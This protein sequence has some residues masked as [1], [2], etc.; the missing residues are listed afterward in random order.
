MK[1]YLFVTILVLALSAS[2]IE[3]QEKYLQCPV[4]HVTVFRQGAQLYGEIPVSIGAETVDFVAGG[5]SPYIDPNS[6]QVR[7]EGGFMI[8]GVSHRNNYLENPDEAESIR[9]LRDRIRELEL[10]IEDEKTAVEILMEKELFLKSNYDVVTN[11]SAITPEQLR[12]LLDIYSSNTEDVKMAVLK[13]RRV[14]KE[15]EEEKQKLEKQLSA[16]V[17]MSKMP[18][19]EILVTVTGTKPAT[20]RLK[21]SYVV[22]NAGWRPSYDIRVDDIADPA[23]IIY[24]AGI[25]Q[26]SGIDWKDVKVS[27]SN[28]S[29]MTAGALPKLNPWFIDFY[30]PIAYSQLNEVVMIRGAKSMPSAREKKADDAIMME[31]ESAPLP[32]TVTESNISFSFDVNVPQTI[33]SGGKTETVELQRLTAPATYSYAVTPKLSTSAY[34]MGYITDWEKYNLLA[35]ESN[36]YF[37]NTFTGKGY[38]N[39]AELT[40]TLPVSLGADNS[41]TVKRER[42]TDYTSQRLIGSNKVE[43]LSFL[44]SLRNTKNRSVS[45]KLRD[46]LPL[47]QNSDITVEAVELTGGNHNVT[48]GEIVWDLTVEPQQTKEIIL[49]YSVKYPKKEKVVLE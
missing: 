35:G 3:G 17:D 45:V 18:T 19:G 39:T 8:M 24:K 42:R 5:L 7:G 40:D 12:A 34:L 21:L 16:T 48:T 23:T 14:I 30:R 43:T 9:K 33:K 15:F 36:I 10:K 25:W 46:Q 37:S 20:G 6:I 38:I 49:T 31:A 28:A 2:A 26:N 22:M 4:T 47:P 1:K 29:P 41:I 27:L 32:V 13:K 11:K 44:I